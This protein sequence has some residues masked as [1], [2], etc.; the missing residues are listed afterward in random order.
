MIEKEKLSIRIFFYYHYF[1]D[2]IHNEN[3]Q[4]LNVLYISIYIYISIMIIWWSENG[5]NS[6]KSNLENLLIEYQ[7]KKLKISKLY[8]IN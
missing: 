5:R 1:H 6:E 3:N 4:V 8:F 7:R 2:I